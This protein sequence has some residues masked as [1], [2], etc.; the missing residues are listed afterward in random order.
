VSFDHW[1]IGLFVDEAAYQRFK[2]DFDAATEKAVLSPP[3]Q[4]AVAAWRN[5]PS[6]FEQGAAPVGPGTEGEANAFIWAFNLPGFDELAKQLFVQGGKFADYL[7]EAHVFRMAIC[8]RH[9][10]VSILWHAI[11]Y[12]RGRLLPGR[13][14][15]L[16]LHPRE[17]EAASE[18]TRRAYVATSPQE[19]LDAARR[20]CGWS[21]S[22]DTLRDVIDFLPDGLTRAAELQ[23]GF[24]ALAR[25]QV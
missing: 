18:K 5:R 22:D 24:L 4:Q 2:P 15:N 3:S 6:D 19:L 8:A 9:T 20:Y 21:V 1:W 11:G 12:E 13:M 10:P 23:R 7:V 25:P 16:L 14:G 17:I